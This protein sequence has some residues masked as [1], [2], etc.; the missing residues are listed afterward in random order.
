MSDQ[1]GRQLA[2]QSRTCAAGSSRSSSNSSNSTSDNRSS[3][4]AS[5]LKILHLEDNP[6]DQEIVRRSLTEKLPFGFV[7]VNRQRGEDAVE[8]LRKNHYDLLLV[9]YHLP[10]MTGLDFMRR[11][12]KEK[13]TIPTMFITGMGDIKLAV[14]AMKEGARNYIVKDQIA[15][16]PQQLAQTVVDYVLEDAFPAGSDKQDLSAVVELFAKSDRLEFQQSTRLSSTPESPKIT[17]NLFTVLDWL[18][19]TKMV[20]WTA[21]RTVVSCPS[22]KSLEYL[23]FFRCPTCE[24]QLLEKGDTIRHV[25]CGCTELTKYYGR[26][27][28]DYLCPS[29]KRPLNRT[30]A[31]YH[32]LGNWYRCRGRHVFERPDP[33]FQCL[34][35]G[36]KFNLSSCALQELASYTLSEEGE[37]KLHLISAAK[38]L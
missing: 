4:V 27:G 29:C 11:L 2:K 8:E 19:S 7:L 5:S 10:D 33:V 37:R 22:C 9:D 23:P 21:V 18:R 17:S 20:E 3:G 26:S 1:D 31:D 24:S 36:V 16:N 32:K 30:H 12:T 28:E 6:D 15:S 13:L 34:K 35:C 25:P 14:E 38:A